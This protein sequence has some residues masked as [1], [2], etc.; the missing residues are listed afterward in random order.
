MSFRSLGKMKQY[1]EALNFCYEN[2]TEVESRAGKVKKC[3]GYQMQFDLSDGF[4]AVTTKKLAW[5]SVVSELLWF[6]EGS[7]DER[8]LAEILYQDKRENLKNKKTIWTQNAKA[9]YWRS[10][11]KFEGDVGKIYGVQWRDF[12]GEDQLLNLIN[13]LKNDPD[14]R[15]HIISSWNPPEL[16][17]MSLPPCHTFSQFFVSNNKLSCHLYQRSCDMFLGVPFNI[18]SYSLFTHMLAKECNFEVG[19]FIHT[20]GDFHIYEEHYDQVKTQL[21]RKPK[22]LSQL[23]FE[24]KNFFEYKVDDFILVDY[25]YHPKLEAVMNV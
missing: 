23:Q 17:N 25:E 22:K 7:D 18:A 10:K 15:R 14:S 21:K 16:K 20:L 3:F 4:P 8:R 5:K 19:K 6:I 12:N 24:P 9:D 1:L 11:S 13:S 2:G